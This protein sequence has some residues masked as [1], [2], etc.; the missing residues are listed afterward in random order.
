MACEV[1]SLGVIYSNTHSMPY[2]VRARHD[3]PK[4]EPE[5]VHVHLLHPVPQAPQ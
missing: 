2:R 3:G 1:V 4:I 5:A